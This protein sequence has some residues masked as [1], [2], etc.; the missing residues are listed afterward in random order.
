MAFLWLVLQQIFK[1]EHEYDYL[2][3]RILNMTLLNF[4]N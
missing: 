2:N 1:V 4:W 3:V